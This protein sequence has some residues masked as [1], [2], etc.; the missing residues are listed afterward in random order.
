MSRKHFIITALFALVAVIIMSVVVC[1][2]PFE[3]TATTNYTAYAETT[4]TE[5]PEPLPEEEP[6]EQTPPEESEE[7]TD[8]TPEATEPESLTDSIIAYLKDVYGDDYQKYYDKIIEHWG[9]LEEYILNA[10]DSL[11]E[12][13]KYNVQQITAAVNTYIGVAANGLLLICAGIY[14]IS[15]RKKN[16]K[17]N[18]DLEALKAA[19][20]QTATANIAIIQAQ[21]A[22]NE[23]F[24]A[25]MPG[26]KFEAA[27]A[28]LCACDEALTA[29]EEEVKRDV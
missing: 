12:E 10:A 6:T 5:Q 15:R 2:M 17:I 3:P 29:A 14:I 27:T 22:Q 1:V 9:S 8:E 11:P 19:Q 13:F 25:L 28:Q 7:V 18:A 16:K 20:N 21:K 24:K 4:V 23:A 26:T